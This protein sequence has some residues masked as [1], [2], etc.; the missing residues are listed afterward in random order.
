MNKPKV[1]TKQQVYRVR[2]WIEDRCKVGATEAE[3]SRSLY[4]DYFAYCSKNHL[5]KI[6]FAHFS[7]LM[8]FFGYA[9]ARLGQGGRAGYSGIA[10]KTA[11]TISELKKSTKTTTAVNDHN[12]IEVVNTATGS[13]N[14]SFNQWLRTQCSRSD[15]Y[16]ETTA[17]LYSHYKE[18]NK[19][20]QVL[21]QQ[22]FS[23]Q[24]KNAGFKK[25]RMNHGGYP[26]WLGLT[27]VSRIPVSPSIYYVYIWKCE[28]YTK[29]GFSR[30]KYAGTII[31]TRNPLA[32]TVLGNIQTHFP[33]QLEHDLHKE[34]AEYHHRGEWFLLPDEV[35]TE[36][37]GRCS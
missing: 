32:I 16:Q 10:L 34:Y 11:P 1:L 13:A 26:G 22:A 37:L 3:L 27:I 14:H 31:D 2:Q 12:E 19:H 21:S 28:S 4:T 20:G 7:R 30:H 29:I 5:G 9:H 25:C 15:Q 6:T 35:L 8:S 24:L 18:W 17:I 23:H 33:R 36:L